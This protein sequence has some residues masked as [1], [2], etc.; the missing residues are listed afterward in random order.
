MLIRVCTRDRG[1]TARTITGLHLGRCTSNPVSHPP[2]RARGGVF[3]AEL[4]L[5]NAEVTQLIRKL[6]PSYSAPDLLGIVEVH[7]RG[8][9]EEAARLWRERDAAVQR[10]TRVADER[11]QV[12]TQLA[13]AM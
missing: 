1:T 13:V 4:V 2:P 11:N 9:R 8:L 7:L 10:A 12:H 5:D 3:Q 6:G